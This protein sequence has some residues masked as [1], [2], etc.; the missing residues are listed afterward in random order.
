MRT[1][2]YF[3]IRFDNDITGRIISVIW[4]LLICSNM[5][6]YM[7]QICKC[8]CRPICTAAPS[9]SWNITKWIPTG[10]F[11]IA[12]FLYHARWW[13]C[14]ARSL[15]NSIHGT[16]FRFPGYNT[17]LSELHAAR[18]NS[19]APGRFQRNFR[20]FIL[21]L[22]LVIGGWSISCKIVFKWMPMDLADG[23]STLV[24]VM[25]WCRQATSH[26]LSQC[27]PR[28]LS[29]YDVTRPQWVMIFTSNWPSSFNWII[30]RCS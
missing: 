10:N 3:E 9:K 17:E 29:P 28:S 30:N 1:N 21:Q 16:D 2:I 12:F 4:Y 11:H 7:L 14:D 22:I 13:T 24:Q 20:K 18:F 26:Y 15:G 23:K 19:L 5:Y 25:A 8:P 6:E 27:W